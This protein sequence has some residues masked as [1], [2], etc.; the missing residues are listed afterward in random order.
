MSSAGRGCMAG[1]GVM[2]T[3]STG[4]DSLVTHGHITRALYCRTLNEGVERV[5]SRGEPRA[6]H[7]AIVSTVGNE[8]NQLHPQES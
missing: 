6:V 3:G 7:G 8:L 2:Q 1:D 4:K 5:E